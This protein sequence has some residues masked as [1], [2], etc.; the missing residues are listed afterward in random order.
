MRKER[1]VLKLL[2]LW[3][4]ELNFYCMHSS[5]LCLHC[6]M[7]F[8]YRQL[9]DKM[10]FQRSVQFTIHLNWAKNETGANIDIFPDMHSNEQ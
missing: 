2:M 7:L 4:D 1:K 9:R 8:L 10:L 3:T 5:T 6:S